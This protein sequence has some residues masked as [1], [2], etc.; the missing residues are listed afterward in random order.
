MR[1]ASTALV[2]APLLLLL[3]GCGTTAPG[4]DEE[5]CLPGRLTIHDDSVTAGG[6]VLVRAEGVECQIQF[7]DDQEYRLVV[8]RAWEPDE[9]Y[10]D[11]EVPVADDGSFEIAFELPPD[12]PSGEAHVAVVDGFRVVCDA[13]ASC[14]AVS[15]PITVL[16]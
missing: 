9:Y 11:L 14:A 2:A 5:A 16:S 15:T 4:F 3:A 8:A 13:D 12:M 6:S 10:V 1:Q 7:T